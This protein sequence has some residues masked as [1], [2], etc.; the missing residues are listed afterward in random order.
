V[1]SAVIVITI[2]A[3]LF[4]AVVPAMLFAVNLRRYR[5]PVGDARNAR[6]SVLIPARDEERNIAACVE[7]VLASDNVELQVIV[8]DDASSDRTA[9]IVGRLA[10]QD[11]RVR[12]LSSPS[13]PQGWNGKQH[14]C[15]LLA[16]EASAPFMLFLD[17]DVRLT[18]AA[19]GLCVGA[20]HDSELDLLSGFPRIVAV[21]WLERLLLPLIHFVLLSFLPMGRMRKTTMP[22]Y[23]AGCGQFLLVKREAYFASGGHSAIRA[24]RHD[25]LRLPQSFRRHHYRTDIFD[26]TSLASVRMYDSSRAVWQGLAK[27][28][29]EGIA[30]PARIVPFTLL[31]TLGQILPALLLLLLIAAS[32]EFAVVGATPDRPALLAAIATAILLAAIASYL[33]RLIA[34]RRFRQ[35]LLSALLHPLGV[36]VLLTVQ[37]YAL[38]RQIARRPIAWRS[39]T[40]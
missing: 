27:N 8:L 22:A 15:W 20:M 24:T 1:I 31:L 2:F 28:A 17:A 37:W 26:L 29:T 32:A 11:A 6:I 19:L 35:P 23:A 14:A 3:S 16:Q 18:P 12:L 34:A 40:S 39:R 4:C 10:E 33:P 9:E 13:L 5:E 36:T 25:G 7:S 30:A 21:G 38:V